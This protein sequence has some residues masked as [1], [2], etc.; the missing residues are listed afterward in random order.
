MNLMPLRYF[1]RRWPHLAKHCKPDADGTVA[2]YLGTQRQYQTHTCD[3]VGPKPTSVQA[4]TDD[5]F[6]DKFELIYDA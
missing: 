5:R 1:S 4:G 2:G 6:E 3:L